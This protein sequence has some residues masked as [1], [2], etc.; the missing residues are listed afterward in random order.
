MKLPQSMFIIFFRMA[1]GRWEPM[2]GRYVRMHEICLFQ[3][4]ST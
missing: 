3:A 4:Y 1:G 2:K